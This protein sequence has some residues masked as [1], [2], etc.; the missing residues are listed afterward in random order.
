[1]FTAPLLQWTAALTAQGPE[2]GTGEWEEE[3]VAPALGI[4]SWTQLGRRKQR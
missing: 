1:M 2:A 3:K 4:Q